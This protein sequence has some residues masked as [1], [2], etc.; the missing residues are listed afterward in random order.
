MTLRPFRP[1]DSAQIL[2]IYGPIIANSSATFEVEVP[3]LS[4][5]TNRLARIAE[6]F[7]F[8]VVESAQEEIL[9][10]A[11][12]T[13]HRERVAYQWAVET[14]VYVAPDHCGKGIGRVLLEALHASLAERGFVWSYGVI[15]L[16]NPA[17]LALLNSMDYNFFAT[18]HAAGQKFGRWYDVQWARFA[19][20]PAE[21]GMAAPRFQGLSLDE[22]VEVR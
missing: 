1:A 12:G 5:F 3:S 10:Y 16:P 20:R 18:Y 15:T 21:P 6:R 7:P 2:A 8:W 22:R 11:Y 13:T 19:L 4:D 9:A 17:S 14:S